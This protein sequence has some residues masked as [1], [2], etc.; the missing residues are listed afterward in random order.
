MVSRRRVPAT[1]EEVADELSEECLAMRLRLLTRVLVGSF[2][3][4]L[5]PLDLTASQMSMLAA[6][7]KAGPMPQGR[8][9]ELLQIEKSTLSRS[10]KRMAKRG[11]VEDVVDPATGSRALATSSKG[12]R[13][14]ERAYPLW[15][16]AQD[17]AMERLG[18]TA[19]ACAF[20]R[21]ANRL[22]DGR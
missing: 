2:D 3:A 22:L 7:T 1:A 6:L 5:R 8:L 21:A 19:G 14:L 10:A 17:A 20:V 11:W 12:R 16:A 13:L 9:G 15:R 4:A 18:V